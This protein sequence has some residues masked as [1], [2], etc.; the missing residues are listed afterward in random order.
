[1]FLDLSSCLSFNLYCLNY[2]LFDFLIDRTRKVKIEIDF[3]KTGNLKY[4][5]SLNN[6]IIEIDKTINTLEKNSKGLREYLEKTEKENR[7]LE[8]WYATELKIVLS[9]L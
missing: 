4:A 7:I 5:E 9:I 6:Q 8:G 3:V 1:M 2:D